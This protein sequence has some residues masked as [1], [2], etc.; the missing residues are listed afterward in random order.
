MSKVGPRNNVTTSKFAI[1]VEKN[2]LIPNDHLR[3]GGVG[4]LHKHGLNALEEF[5]LG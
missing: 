5:P 4:L 3:G 2:P 1:V